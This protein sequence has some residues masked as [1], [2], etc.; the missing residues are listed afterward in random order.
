MEGKSAKLG[1]KGSAVTHIRR[2]EKPDKQRSF[3][4]SIKQRE[5]PT[6]NP[7]PG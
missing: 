3:S 6:G 5:M 4:A 1:L 2:N 7:R